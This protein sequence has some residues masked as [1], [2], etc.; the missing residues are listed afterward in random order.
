MPDQKVIK[1]SV[2]RITDET[3]AKDFELVLEIDPIAAKQI[4]ASTYIEV[5]LTTPVAVNIKLPSIASLGGFLQ[6]K[7]FCV[8]VAG[9]VSKEFPISIR[10]ADDKSNPESIMGNST[11]TQIV[12]KQGFQLSPVS[13]NVWFS[14]FGTNICDG[15]PEGAA[16][17]M[18]GIQ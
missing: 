10:P 11:L 6:Y 2:I 9:T 15:Q 7:I 5:D 3:K 17:L 8:D 14:V 16:Y 4:G 18:A 13:N 1:G 12:A